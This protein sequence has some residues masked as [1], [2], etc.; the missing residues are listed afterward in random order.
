MSFDFVWNLSRGK[1]RY[2]CKVLNKAKNC[3]HNYA[4]TI[5]C[6][7]GGYY[8]KHQDLHSVMKLFYLSDGM[9][10]TFLG[11]DVRL[12]NFIFLSAQLQNKYGSS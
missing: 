2:S 3:L 7:V 4:T 10:M 5:E 6:A 9:Y 11:Y 12:N 8:V 1:L